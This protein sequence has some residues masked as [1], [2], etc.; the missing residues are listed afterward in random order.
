MNKIRAF[1]YIFTKSLTTPKYYGDILAARFSLTLKYYLVLSLV[2]SAV[3]AGIFSF[4]A[5]PQIRAFVDEQLMQI[6][7]YYPENLEI[8]AKD[9]QLSINQPEPYIVPIPKDWLDEMNKD[10]E[11]ELSQYVGES[12]E[13]EEMEQMQKIK[14]IVVFKSDGTI[15]DLENFNTFILVN[16]KNMIYRDSQKLE[17]VPLSDVPDGTFTKETLVGGLNEFA[18]ILER[19]VG[20]SVLFFAIALLFYFMV[21]RG[22][23]SVVVA[24]LLW[25]VGLFLKKSLPFLKYWQLSIHAM[26]LPLVLGVVVIFIPSDYRNYIVPMW[27]LGVHYIFAIVALA[28]VSFGDNEMGEVSVGGGNGQSPE[29]M[30]S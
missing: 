22:V 28:G 14:N 24:V 8:T 5:L 16:S 23:Y 1:F 7:D 9:G 26:T 30:S 20:L 11:E 29:N 6:P 4:T 18:P 10:L 15:N 21:L 12:R 19:F 13:K 25:P 2:L 3:S 17:V 27:F